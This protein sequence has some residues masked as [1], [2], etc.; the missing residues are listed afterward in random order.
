[1]VV[2]QLNKALA[3]HSG[4]PKNSNSSPFHIL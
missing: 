3:D 1:V 4:R 2:E